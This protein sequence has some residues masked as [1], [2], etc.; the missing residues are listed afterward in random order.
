MTVWNEIQDM[1]GEIFDIPTDWEAGVREHVTNFPDD[2]IEEVCDWV[3]QTHCPV[4]RD[5]EDRIL[6]IMLEEG[7]HHQLDSWDEV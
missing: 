6:E 1:P 3:E 2:T 7:N 4:D 5:M